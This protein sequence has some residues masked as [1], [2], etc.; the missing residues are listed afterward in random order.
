VK[1]GETIG[2]FGYLGETQLSETVIRAK[3]L[4]C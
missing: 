4:F 2:R 3:H 1:I